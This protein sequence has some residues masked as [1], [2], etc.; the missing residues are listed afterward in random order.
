MAEI[1]LESFGTITELLQY[2]TGSVIITQTTGKLASTGI[3]TGW[4]V[5]DIIQLSGTANSNIEVTVTYIH[6]DA[7]Y[8]LTT[9]NSTVFGANETAANGKLNQVKYSDWQDV[10]GSAKLV[11]TVNS[12]GNCVAYVQQSGDG[13]NIDYSTTVSVTGG[14]AASFSI[15]TVAGY[16]RIKVLTSDA[17]QTV[18]R[19]YFY[20]RINT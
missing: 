16:A 18:M 2:F 7:S 19:T 4:T 15:E 12:S 14:T 13:I 1:L 5:G 3:G 20:G 8:M 9:A 11:G 6:T 10:R 17:D